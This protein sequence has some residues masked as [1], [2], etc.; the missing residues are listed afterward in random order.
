MTGIGHCI[1]SLPEADRC[2]FITDHGRFS[3][4]LY[5][6]SNANSAFTVETNFECET[7]HLPKNEITIPL[8]FVH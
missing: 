7:M 5:S 8:R 2:K 4:L 1:R 3:Q 6:D